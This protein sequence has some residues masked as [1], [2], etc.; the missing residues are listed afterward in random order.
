MGMKSLVNGLSHSH[1]SYKMSN[2]LDA[3]KVKSLVKFEAA[4]SSREG[5]FP[6]IYG[7]LNIDTN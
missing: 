3:E 4:R 2:L 7:P 6:H 1:E 5:L